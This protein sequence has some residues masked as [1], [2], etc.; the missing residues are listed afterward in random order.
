[1]TEGKNFPDGFFAR[2]DEASDPEFYQIARKVVHIDDGAIEAVRQ[3]Y[4]EVLPPEGPILDLMSSWRS[5]LPNGAEGRE[6]VGLGLNEEEMVDNPQLTR[7]VVHDLNR[8]T[9]LPFADEEFAAV[10]C[11]VSVQYMTRPIDTF[12]EVRRILMSGGPFV[13]TFSNRCF[14]TKAI[15]AW[16]SLGDDEH[17]RL[18]ALY[19]GR[20]GGWDDVTAVTRLEGV[21][22][23]RD[24]LY[25]AWARKA[26]G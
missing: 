10:V 17:K 13:V 8:A 1:M 7:R 4:A 23:V 9:A 3:L 22:G 26:V 24:P 18:V 20:S 19:F 5:H 15:A 16:R 25:A 11:S 12:R 21:P 6:V 2:E 14:P